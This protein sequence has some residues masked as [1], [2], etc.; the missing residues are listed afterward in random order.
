MAFC[1]HR[2]DLDER[3]AGGLGGRQ[4]PRR[5]P[6]H[7]LRQRRLRRRALLRHAEG[8]GGLPPRRAHQAPAAIG[9]DLPD[10][11][12]LHA[13]SSSRRP[14]SRPSA[15]TASRPATSGRSMYRGY[16]ALGVNPLTCP[17]DVG[18][19]WSGNGARTSA[20]RRS[21]RAWTCASARGTGWRRTRSRR[22]PRPAAT[23][24]TPQLIR[25]E[26]EA[27]GY[28]EGIALDT[29]GYVSEGSGENIFVVRD[30]VIY[31]PPLAPRSCRASRATWSCSIAR[32][33]GYRVSR[34]HPAA[35]DAL[36]RRRGVLRRHGRRDHARSARSTGSRSA[37]GAA[38]R[39]P[40]P[41]SGGSSASISGDGPT[42]TAGSPT[43]TCRRQPRAGATPPREGALIPTPAHGRYTA[44]VT[45]GVRGVHLVRLAPVSHPRTHPAMHINDSAEDRGRAQVRPTCI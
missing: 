1:G 25:M 7:P 24:R 13:G 11:L 37:T 35:R 10:G 38:G 34:R 9:E 2:Q 14:C 26:A 17:V 44:Q 27:N 22:W 18:R 43:S 30:G 39:S 23:T 16:D 6:R 45:R 12:S 4:D 32:D 15:P 3:D 5:V 36:H 41:F 19:S 28:T 40:R 33:L 42:R 21:R 31:T 8:P 29:F 20:P